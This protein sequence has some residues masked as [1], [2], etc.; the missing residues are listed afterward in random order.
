MSSVLFQL[1]RRSVSLF[2]LRTGKCI[3]KLHSQGT[4]RAA[5]DHSTFLVH[6]P[7]EGPHANSRLPMGDGPGSSPIIP[8]QTNLPK[9]T[10]PQQ[11]PAGK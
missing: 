9:A 8:G 10:F 3:Q 4:P 11:D 6:P 7:G 2:S 1:P 5:N